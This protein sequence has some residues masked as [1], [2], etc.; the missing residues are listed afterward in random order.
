MAQDSTDLF[1]DIA[2]ADDEFFNAF[3][4]CDLARMGELD[5]AFM[6]TFRLSDRLIAQAMEQYGLTL[7]VDSFYDNIE[8]KVSEPA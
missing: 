5:F 4:V 1:A 6:N 8:W 2:R 7:L 3:N